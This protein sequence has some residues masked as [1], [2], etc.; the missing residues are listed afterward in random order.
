MF[1]KSGW[2][3]VGC[4]AQNVGQLQDA[5]SSGMDISNQE[6]ILLAY[7]GRYVGVSFKRKDR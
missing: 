7:I 4:E 5:L 6:N 2:Q 1:E 3:G